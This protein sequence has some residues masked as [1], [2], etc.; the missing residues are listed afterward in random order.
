M[1]SVQG[2]ARVPVQ[3]AAHE[4][5]RPA[6]TT[7]FSGHC[8]GGTPRAVRMGMTRR[9]TSCFSSLNLWKWSAIALAATS[10]MGCAGARYGLEAPTSSPAEIDAAG[11]E[12]KVID[13]RGAPAADRVELSAPARLGDRASRRVPVGLTTGYR[14]V[15]EEMLQLP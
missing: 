2:A 10:L 3:G 11:I 7:L 1:H 5:Q 12:L 8:A 13:T 14:L 6:R 4:A 15:I 9:K